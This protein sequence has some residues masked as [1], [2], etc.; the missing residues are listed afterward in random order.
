MEKKQTIIEDDVWIGRNVIF[1]PGR[2]VRKG[3]IIGAGCVLTKDFDE[4][5]I[6]G[7]NP[8]RVIRS[9]N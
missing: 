5:T 8:S 9:R 6:I 1:T 2:T 3:S 4:Y 7:G